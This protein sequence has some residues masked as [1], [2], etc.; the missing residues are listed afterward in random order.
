VIGALDGGLRGD[1]EPGAT[2]VHVNKRYRIAKVDDNGGASANVSDQLPHEPPIVPY[3]VHTLSLSP[4]KLE[5]AL[6]ASLGGAP[7]FQIRA[8][9]DGMRL[10]HQPRRSPHALS[11][12]DDATST[13]SFGQ[14]IASSNGFAV[15]TD[16]TNPLTRE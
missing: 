5:R 2:A 3:L 12:S 16:P 1:P 15:A 14:A 9:S 4:V 8:E 11:N 10:E 6:S 13:V 7:T